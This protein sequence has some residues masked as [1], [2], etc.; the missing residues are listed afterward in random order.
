M[1]IIKTKCYG[2]NNAGDN[3][4][5]VYL[6]DGP[7]TV[8]CVDVVGDLEKSKAESELL[9]QYPK[10]E[11]VE[12][13]SLVQFVDDNDMSITQKGT[14]LVLVFYIDRELLKNPEIAGPF[15]HSINEIIAIRDMNA[16]ALF[17]P[18]DGIERV[19]AINPQIATTQQQKQIDV[20]IAGI[21]KDFQIDSTKDLSEV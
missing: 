7:T 4:Y 10:I 8:S 18:T 5:L 15:V 6:Y 17:M 13:I 1:K 16:I 3:K 9:T 12:N 19:E 20:L 11:A 21:E 2:V 14:P